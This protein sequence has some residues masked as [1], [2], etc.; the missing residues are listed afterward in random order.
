MAPRQLCRLQD[1]HGRYP[2]RRPLRQLHVNSIA[3]SNLP[4]LE[5]RMLTS[6]PVYCRLNVDNSMFGLEIG[7]HRLGSFRAPS[8]QIVFNINK[9]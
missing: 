1:Q 2:I 8:S 3:T 5:I 4:V 7:R 6:I 9:F